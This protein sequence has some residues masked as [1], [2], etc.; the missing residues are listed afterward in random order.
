VQ[1]TFISI[2]FRR[3][4]GPIKPN[5]QLVPRIKQAEREA[6]LSPPCGGEIKNEWSYTSIPK[7]AFVA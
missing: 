5:I 4:L 6:H 1:K 3:A 7:Y 2:A